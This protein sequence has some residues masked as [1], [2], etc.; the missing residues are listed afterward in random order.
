MFYEGSLPPELFEQLLAGE[1]PETIGEIFPEEIP[2]SFSD[3]IESVMAEVNVKQKSF[4][5]HG[6]IAELGMYGVITKEMA[7]QIAS[8]LP[9]AAVL[10][11]PC[12]GRGFFA[13]AMR[14]LGFTVIAGDREPDRPITEILAMDALKTIDL[15]KE[16]D[17][18]V[19]CM[20]WMPRGKLDYRLAKRWGD[21]PI[22]CLGDDGEVTGSSAFASGFEGEC[23]DL[24]ASPLLHVR[25]YWSLGRFSESES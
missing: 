20:I 18:A 6:N 12:A 14:E 24:P 22:L 2:V 1:V 9:P 4:Q 8:V 7:R 25:D 10:V 17:N 21:R 15:V 19:L 16:E 13:K 11:D 5:I 23:E 3:D